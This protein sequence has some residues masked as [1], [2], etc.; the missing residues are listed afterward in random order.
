MALLRQMFPRFGS[1]DV[2]V[3]LKSEPLVSIIIP[4]AGKVVTH[5]GRQIDLI[6]NCIDTILGRSTVCAKQLEF[7]IV[8]NGD[9]DR[10]RLAHV[11]PS[12]LKFATFHEPELNVAKKLNIGATIASGPIFLLLNDDTEPLVQS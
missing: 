4:T 12:H 11:D 5:D 3:T 7:V 10:S 1:Y 9:F 2:Q 8:D 6:V